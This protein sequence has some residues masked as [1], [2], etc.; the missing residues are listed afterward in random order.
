MKRRKKYSSRF[1]RMLEK[2][3]NS[4]SQKQRDFEGEVFLLQM[5]MHNETT[6]E[7]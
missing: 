2:W 7:N 4:M 5:K 1:F 6:K 3:R